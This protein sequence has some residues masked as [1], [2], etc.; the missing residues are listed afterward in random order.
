MKSLKFLFVLSLVFAI[1]ACSSSDDGD[2]YDFVKDNLVG[3][4]NLAYYKS[5]ETTKVMVEGFEV[6]TKT[7][8]DADTYGMTYDF[9][10]DN[11]LTMDGTYRVLKK[12]TQAGQ[13]TDTIYIVSRNNEKVSYNV[14]PAFD[15]LLIQAGTYEVR[16]F[17]P[18]GFKVVRE[19]EDS[20]R[21]YREEMHF[22]R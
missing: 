19:E 6:T 10:A 2:D 7:V 8:L 1:A 5:T 14:L 22:T 11:I 21:E 18:N 16:D 13:T 20:N 15:Q 3:K 17:N 12:K 4:Y 9:G